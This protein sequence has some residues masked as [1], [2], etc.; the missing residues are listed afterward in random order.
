[1]RIAMAV[2]RAAEVDDLARGGSDEFYAGLDHAD[3]AYSLNRREMPHGNIPTFEELEKTAA[4]CREHGKPLYLTLNKAYYLEEEFAVAQHTVERA[5]ACGVDGLIV[6]DP[7]LMEWLASEQAFGMKLHLSSV[8]AA[9]NSDAIA[10]FTGYGIRRAILP[11]LTLDEIQS[12][13]R[14]HPDIELEAMVLGWRCPNMDGLCS[15]QHDFKRFGD[16]N[17]PDTILTNGCSL[18]YTV[19]AAGGAAGDD[20]LLLRVRKRFRNVLL[21]MSAACEACYLWDLSAAG[22]DVAKV[23]ARLLDKRQRLTCL[24]FMKRCVELLD[25]A[26]SRENYAYAVKRLYKTTF[27][28]D[29]AGNCILE[30]RR[31]A[32]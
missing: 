12:V 24:R 16:G 31:A 3:Y 9:M 18:Q 28:F 26:D 19:N 1:M 14:A 7:G 15:F 2:C 13:R 30:P 8:A 32:K 23:V 21:R 29:C 27:G 6:S 5:A 25:E 10:F 11:R 4:L 22:V 20:L 17:Y